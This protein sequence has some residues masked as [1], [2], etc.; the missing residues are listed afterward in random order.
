MKMNIPFLDLRITNNALRQNY[1]T[2]IDIVF[3]HGRFIL[4]K[5]TKALYQRKITF[6]VYILIKLKVN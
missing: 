6:L 5:K 2:A 1:L 3:K 4:L